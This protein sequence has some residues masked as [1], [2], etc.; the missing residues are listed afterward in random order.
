MATRGQKKLPR[1]SSAIAR[2]LKTRLKGG[3]RR[4]Q[5]SMTRIIFATVG[6]VFSF[7]FAEKVLGHQQPIFAAT[8]ALIVLGFANTSHIRRTLEVAVGCTL[9]IVLGDV[10]MT[11]LGRGVWQAGIVVFLSLVLARF[12]DPGVVFATQLGVQSLL[13]VLLPIPYGGPFTRS[14]DAVIGGS[15]G[16][17]LML[18]W[19]RDP[20]R[21][22]A[23]KLSSLMREV[24]Q[25]FRELGEALESSDSQ[26]AWHTLVRVRNASALVDQARQEI[27]TSTDYAKLSVLGRRHRHELSDQ[28]QLLDV[29]DLILRGLNVVARRAAGLLNTLA[30]DAEQ[31]QRLHVL[32]DGFADALN[33]LANSAAETST[34]SANMMRR[35]ARSIMEEVVGDLDASSWR[36]GTMQLPTLIM[37]LRPIAVDILHATGVPRDAASDYLPRT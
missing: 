19:P 20:R 21:A 6:S 31:R 11:L 5:I 4:V 33:A 9:G 25:C 24:S 3:T 10:L 30:P 12:L 18:M 23:A 37:L 1:A 34:G 14:I 17:L 27:N 16:L 7:W 15:V 8:S 29:A 32:F 28:E 26:A 2:D 35:R 13:V 36:S 22:P